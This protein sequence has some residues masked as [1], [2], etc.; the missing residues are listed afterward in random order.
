MSDFSA[1]PIALLDPT[2]AYARLASGDATLIDVRTQAEWAFV[3]APDLSA[4][5]GRLHLI[6][7]LSFPQMRPNPGFIDAALAAIEESG[8]REA[9]F[10][11]RSGARSHQAAETMQAEI[12]ARGATVACANV[13]EGF[14]GD[15]DAEG[16]RGRVNG[17]KARGLPWRQS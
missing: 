16:R 8:A 10:L 12:A 11:C 6:E 7:W 4:T 3:G 9:L 15:L 17:W 13:V 2:E 14:E 1:G 5:P